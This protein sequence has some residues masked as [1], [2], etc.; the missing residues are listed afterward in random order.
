M[1]KLKNLGA[2]SGL[3]AC[4]FLLASP[5][6]AQLQAQLQANQDEATT[7]T[8]R[9]AR[10]TSIPTNIPTTTESINAQRIEQTINASDSS[11]VLKYFPSLVVRKR[12]SGD[13][14]HAVLASRASGTG[15]SARSLVYADG[16][17]LSN[18]LGN[19]ASFT[20]RWGL[21]TPEEIERVDVLYGPFSAAYSGNSV[22]AVVDYL[23]RMP[24]KFEAHAK[25]GLSSQSFGLY[26]SKSTFNGNQVSASLGSAA[27]DWAWWVSVAR[28]ASD[29]QPMVF[30]NRL[31]SSGTSGTAGTAVSGA[32]LESDPRNRPWY[33]LGSSNQIDTVQEH[34]KLKVAYSFSPT[35]KLSY[36]FGWWHNEANRSSE[37][38]LKDAAGNPVYGGTVN[39]GG[40]SFALTA[41]DF[42]L[43]RQVLN[44][45]M[46]G[47]TLKS[48]AKSYF[49]YELSVSQYRYGRDISS[50]T[51]TVLPAASSGGAGR[52]TNLGGTGWNN[53]SLKGT[54]RPDGS[55]RSAH[56]I[57]FG[58]QQDRFQ[59][60]SSTLNT[61]DWLTGVTGSTFAGST[62]DT[63]LKSFYVQDT[64]RIQPTMRASLG[65]RHET[66]TAS[67][68]SVTNP[69]STIGL[70]TRNESYLSPKAAFAYDLRDD[71][72]LKASY[73]RSVRFPT[74]SEL[75]QGSL[76]SNVLI[77]NDP[78]LKAERANTGELSIEHTVN[79]GLLRATIF[80]EKTRDALYSQT[81]VSVTPNVTNI[82][83]IDLIKT[84]GIEVAAYQGDAFVKGLT[85][86]GSV[87][88]ADST[89]LANAKF[90]ASIGGQQPRVPN[91]RAHA[92]AS[93]QVNDKLTTTLG[94]R[95]SGKQFGTLDNVDPN[96]SSYTGFSKYFVVDTRVLYRFTPNWIGSVGID[97]LTNRKYWAFH[98]YPQRTVMLD[99]KYQM[100]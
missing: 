6:E 7:V 81:N 62:G 25:I 56:T 38:Y 30:A 63:Q 12:Y 88:Y 60:R 54:W 15:N 95:Y 36:T 11:D 44:H 70:N 23:T 17:L 77:N 90:P 40:R 20:P 65:L 10:P 51:Q 45:Q 3:P 93:Y 14:D 4:L 86:S 69:T 46:H 41:V 66:W 55:T 75:Y 76:S 5:A 89:I 96:G 94:A 21:V 58:F 50:A 49:D 29:G 39:I 83:N 85:L 22:G 80:Q 37:T 100:R 42:P 48:N 32:V 43:Q 35:V 74:V 57:D 73:G 27:G 67:N 33:L 1:K 47:L 97:N 2:Y 52:L 34:A 59:L 18:L 53:L 28:Q 91:W 82:Q 13:F 92:V 84:T 61:A 19:G 68:G 71:L 8:V 16:I 31:V 78:N 87:T 9:G 99:L 26:S 98:P 64:W 79:K 24:T 72:T